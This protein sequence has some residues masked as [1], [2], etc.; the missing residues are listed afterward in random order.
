MKNFVFD[1]YGTLVDIRTDEHDG[2]FQ[3]RMAKYFGCPDFWQRYISLCKEQET[4]DKYCEIDLLKVFSRLAPERPARSAKYFRDKSRS[5]LK[6]YAGIRQLLKKLKSKGAKLFILS[7][8]QSCFTVDE[9][10]DTKLIKYFDAIVLSSD[11]G[12][13]K[14]SPEFFAYILEKYSLEKE[15]TVYIGNDFNADILGASEAGLSTAYI[16]SNLSPETDS[17]NEALSV[18]GFATDSFKKLAEY[19]LSL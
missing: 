16:N 9:L 13:K 15:Q 11:F 17:L 18:S 2:K 7:N 4:G 14:P 6:V 1:L 8:A 10:K 5:K 12:K 3:K 19:L